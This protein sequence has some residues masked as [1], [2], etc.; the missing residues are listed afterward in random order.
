MYIR[1]HSNI[2]L[3]LFILSFINHN[4]ILGN[5]NAILIHRIDKIYS[6]F[7][8]IFYLY[9]N[10][11]KINYFWFQVS[12][13]CGISNILVYYL[14]NINF[15]FLIHIGVLFG[16]LTYFNGLQQKIL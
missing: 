3:L 6:I 5:K 1:L 11:I 15:K 10:L 14:L 8:A 7:V 9:L 12:F 2:F 4:K 16:G 13:I